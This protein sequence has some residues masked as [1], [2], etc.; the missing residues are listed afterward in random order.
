MINPEEPDNLQKEEMPS[1]I[2]ESLSE[3]KP[4]DISVEGSIWSTLEERTSLVKKKPK[5]IKNFEIEEVK[6]AKG[7][8]EYI[9]KDK[10]TGRYHKLG[11][12]QLFIWNLMDGEHTTRDIMI[13]ATNKF[14]FF[15]GMAVPN[16]LQYFESQGLIEEKYGHIYSKLF[17]YFESKKL[18]VKLM[19]LWTKISTHGIAIKKCD[20]FIEKV[21]SATSFLYN[22]FMIVP[23]LLLGAIGLGIFFLNYKTIL[24]EQKMFE[25][26][27][28]TVLGVIVFFSV[29]AFVITTHE[30]AHAVTCKHYGREVKK[31]GFMLYLIMPTFYADTS[32][33]WMSGRKQR[34]MVSL[35]GPFSTLLL[36]SLFLIAWLYVNPNSLIYSV[37]SKLVLL[38]FV[39]VFF[40]LNPLIATD[41]YYMLS[42]YLE[43]ANL[44]GKAFGFLKQ[45]LPN[46]IVA[47][48]QGKDYS[49]KYTPKQ[50]VFFTFFGAFSAVWTG[51]TLMMGI[52]YWY[53]IVRG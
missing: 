25:F 20:A 43:I 36:G 33:I 23:Y 49:T 5:R 53:G 40:N 17:N 48:L 37:L 6:T 50:E 14:G 7:T 8:T 12:T 45:H 24:F 18:M 9:L 30:L 3:I 42:D 28:S 44:R 15:G 4:E 2:W 31:M 35:A 26:A 47:K 16:V 22:K 34:I 32:D 27:N 38:C 52:N 13:E 21:H 1:G 41:G 39:L 51:V 29:Y 46:K 10:N 19:K 11:E